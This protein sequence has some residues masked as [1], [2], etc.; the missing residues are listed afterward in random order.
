MISFLPFVIISVVL[1]AYLTWRTLAV[2]TSAPVGLRVI[3]LRSNQMADMLSY[4]VSAGVPVDGDV[5]SRVVT[6]TVNGESKGS[7][8]YAGDSVELGVISVPQDSNVVLTLVDV[9]DAGNSSEPA[10]VT[11]VAVDTVAPTQPGFFGVTLVGETHEAATQVVVDTDTVVEPATVV[12][13]ESAE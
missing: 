2:P 11:F 10:T 3:Q 7:T 1:L 9:D 4:K 6:V 12:E 13:P 5:V 8:S